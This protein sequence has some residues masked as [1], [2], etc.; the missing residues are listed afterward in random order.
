MLMCMLVGNNCYHL[1]RS[2]RGER[3][4]SQQMCCEDRMDLIAVYDAP[5][6]GYAFNL[7]VCYSCGT[8]KK[9]DVWENKGTLVIDCKNEIYHLQL[10]PPRNNSSSKS[11]E[12]LLDDLELHHVST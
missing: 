5:K 8:I 9:Q 7:Y 6:T 12:E 4:M 10:N 11:V 1:V 3:E 2:K